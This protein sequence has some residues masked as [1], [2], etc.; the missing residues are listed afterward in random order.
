MAGKVKNIAGVKFNKLTAVSYIG[1]EKW[2]FMCE[3]GNQ[4]IKK[5]SDVKKGSTKACCR[6]CFT[7][8]PSKHPLY[9]TWDGIKKRCYQHN[10]TGY[11][12]YGGRGIKMCENWRISF[13]NFV[14]EMG[15]KPFKLATIER[16]NNNQDYSK[17]NCK[18]A[19]PK[20]Q[21]ENKRNNIYVEYNNQKY[22][23]YAICKLLNL[24]HS[25]VWWRLKKSKLLPQEY[26]NNHI[27]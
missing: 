16:L 27:F 5:A 25:S 3:C 7:G 22:T 11:K 17:E 2:L 9:Q 26:F 4:S 10:A 19:T 14:K 12:N 15:E 13:W 8:N 6:L 21:S 20:E 24:K 23:L 1:A 18:W